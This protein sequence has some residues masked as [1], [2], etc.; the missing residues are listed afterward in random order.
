M[1]KKERRGR[2]NQRQ[3]IA[4]KEKQRRIFDG[5][6]IKRKDNAS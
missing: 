1:T 5:I 3:K 4:R 6:I 2:R